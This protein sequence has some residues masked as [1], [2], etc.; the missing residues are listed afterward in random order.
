MLRAPAV[1][2]LPDLGE[3]LREPHHTI[4][5]AGLVGGG[6]TIRPGDISLTHR[7]ALREHQSA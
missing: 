6:S 7:G 1:A 2:A 5:H 4:S 3:P